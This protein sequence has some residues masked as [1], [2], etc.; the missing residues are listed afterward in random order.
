MA[1]CFGFSKC[2]GLPCNER[3]EGEMRDA[4]LRSLSPISEIWE[5]GP[6]AGCSRLKNYQKVGT[7][8]DFEG[9]NGPYRVF[10][11]RCFMPLLQ[12]EKDK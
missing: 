1:N 7:K 12:A 2:G 5:R 8:G 4:E 9:E 10:P 11:Y 6:K 3:A